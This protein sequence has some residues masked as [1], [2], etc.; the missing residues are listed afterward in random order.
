MGH[1]VDTRRKFDV[2]FTFSRTPLKVQHRA[3]EGLDETVWK[4][5]NTKSQ[6]ISDPKPIIGPDFKCMAGVE[7]NFEQKNAVSVIVNDPIRPVMLHGPPGTGKTA[8]VVEAILQVLRA[9]SYAKVLV[10]TPSNNAA[11]LVASLLMPHMEIGE[12]MRLNGY[13][14]TI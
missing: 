5:L 3:V 6:T 12:L 1:L 9:K 8:T 10:C 2:Q 14:S 13:V 7:L 4:M 11:D